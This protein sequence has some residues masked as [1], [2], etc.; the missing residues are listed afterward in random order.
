MICEPLRHLGDGVEGLG[1]NGAGR[2]GLKIRRAVTNS[3]CLESWALAQKTQHGEKFGGSGL[4]K[5]DRPGSVPPQVSAPLAAIVVDFE[6]SGKFAA[7][8][9]YVS[10]PETCEFGGARARR[11]AQ[12][13]VVLNHDGERRGECDNHR[14]AP[15][16]EVRAVDAASLGFTELRSPRRLEPMNVPAAGSGAIIT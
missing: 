12:R 15:T 3:E 13:G 14:E 11:S 16:L 1:S 9:E 10:L 7:D 8:L 5:I 2:Y 6:V 4:R